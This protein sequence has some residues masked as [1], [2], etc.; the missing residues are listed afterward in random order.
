MHR[1]ENLFALD[2]DAHAELLALARQPAAQLLQRY[3]RA[4]EIDHHDHGEELANHGLA[5]V[6][7]VDIGFGD[8]RRD[9]GD[10]ADPIRADD[11]NDG[12]PRQRAGA[13]A[14]GLL[15]H[16]VLRSNWIASDPHCVKSALLQIAWPALNRP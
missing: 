4:A 14:L 9:S 8:L 15:A 13:F 5:D 16:I 10:D 1:L 6:E 2:F 11:G 12:A 3:L 7:N